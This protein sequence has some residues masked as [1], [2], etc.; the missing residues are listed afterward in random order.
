MSSNVQKSSEPSVFPFILSKASISEIVKKA[1]TAQG[2][3][4]LYFSSKNALISAIAENP[5]FRND[6]N[7][8]L[9]DLFVFSRALFCQ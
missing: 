3:F 4:Y 7:R 2:T 8:G 5:F 9:Q 6:F 1:G